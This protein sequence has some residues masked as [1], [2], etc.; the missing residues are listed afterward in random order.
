MSDKHDR[1]IA[2]VNQMF[3][4]ASELEALHPGRRFTPD[5][6][7]VG[8]LGEVLASA[9]FG[10]TLNPASAKAHDAVAPDGR[11]VQIKLTGGKSVGLRH[12]PEHLLVL[13]RDKDGGVQIAYNGPGAP[14][15]EASGRMAS[16]GQ[17]Q[18][19]LARLRRLDAGVPDDT[20]LAKHSPA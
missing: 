17:R 5:G 7:M 19:S 2:L 18:I 3:A 8:S 9:Q 13:V 16:N 11:A 20:R 14:V 4:I 1:T 12:E 10:L 15:W 6:H